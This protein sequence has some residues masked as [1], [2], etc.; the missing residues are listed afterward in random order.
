M[1]TKNLSFGMQALVAFGTVIMA[2]LLF[3]IALPFAAKA[4]TPLTGYVG[5]GSNGSNVSNLQAYLATNPDIY[6]SGKVTGHFGPLTMAAVQ[7]LQAHYDIA[8]V[9]RVGPVTLATLNSLINA[10]LGLDLRSALI[11]AFGAQPGA[12]TATVNWSTDTSASGRVY[13]ST[14]PLQMIEATRGRSAPIISGSVASAANFSTSQS[15]TLSNLQPSTTYYYVIMTMD[16]SGNVS[17][18]TQQTFRTLP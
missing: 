17:V 1:T 13:Y 5:I 4:A 8:Q 12:N 9:G 3:Y 10:G 7:Q 2:A 18:T 16:A 14:S 15:V 6:P 11:L